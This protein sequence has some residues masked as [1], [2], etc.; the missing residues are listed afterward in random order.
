MVLQ[1]NVS[2][3]ALKCLRWPDYGSI[4]MSEMTRLWQHWNVW[5][6]Q[7][8]AALFV[9]SS[10]LSAIFNAMEIAR[11]RQINFQLI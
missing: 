1:L 10:L 8:M 11:G 3:V 9:A 5:D 6:D 2:L 7:I 4:E